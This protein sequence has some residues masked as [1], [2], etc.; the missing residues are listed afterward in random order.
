MTKKEDEVY[1]LP[2]PKCKGLGKVTVTHFGTYNISFSVRLL[3][4]P[5]CNGTGKVRRAKADRLRLKEAKG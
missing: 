4:C 5:K 3:P 1:V 2:C